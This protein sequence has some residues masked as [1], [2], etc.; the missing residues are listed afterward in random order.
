M[1][2]QELRRVSKH[3]Y[4]QAPSWISELMYGEAVHKWSCLNA[5]ANST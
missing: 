5:A 3:G 4:I 2:Y 1:L